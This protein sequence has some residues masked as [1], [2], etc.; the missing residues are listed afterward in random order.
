MSLPTPPCDHGLVIR[1]DFTDEAGGREARDLLGLPIDGDPVALHF[2]DDPAFDGLTAR[3]LGEAAADADIT[4]AFLADA[5]TI[6]ES[7]PTRSTRTASS[8]GSRPRK[9]ARRR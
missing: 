3:Q 4:Y 1:T 6:A 8:A 2:V 5:D 7:T 9:L